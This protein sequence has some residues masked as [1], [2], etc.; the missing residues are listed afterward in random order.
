MIKKINKILISAFFLLLT[1]HPVWADHHLV[2]ISSV[3]KINDAECAVELTIYGDNQNG[4][5]SDD[6][7]QIDGLEAVDF[8]PITSLL[9]ASSG[10]NDTGDTILLTSVSFDSFA[11]G[12][13]DLTFSDSHCA[14]LDSSSLVAFYND[15][16]FLV[17]SVAMSD[18]SGFG[19]NRAIVRS[20]E[21]SRPVLL[22]IATDD[23]V[24]RNNAGDFVGVGTEDSDD[25]LGCSLSTR[26]TSSASAPFG[27][28]AFTALFFFVWKWKS[29]KPGKIH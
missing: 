17:D 3:A 10:N 1:T 16:S 5:A 18:V 9:N 8:S 25:G 13:A 21:T 20:T 22:N 26:S 28:L 6:Q 7:L 24:L 29:S 11:D 2:F 12:A 15:G 23:L 27:M 19:S 14:D 4:F